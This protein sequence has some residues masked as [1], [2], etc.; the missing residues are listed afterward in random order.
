MSYIILRGRLCVIIVLNVHAPSE[1]KTD[2]EGQLA[3][4][5]ERVFYK[6]LKAHM[7]M[8]LGNYNAKAKEDIL[9]PTIENEN[10]HE[11]NNGNRV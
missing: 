6:L 2:I 11:I 1:N 7:K 9:Q 8:L 5:V 3:E 10:L 4:E